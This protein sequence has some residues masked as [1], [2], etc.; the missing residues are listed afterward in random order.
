[1]GIHENYEYKYEYGD[2]ESYKNAKEYVN[3]QVDDINN[4]LNRLGYLMK[5]F[6]KDEPDFFIPDFYIRNKGIRGLLET[7]NVRNCPAR[8]Y[9]HFY[10]HPVIYVKKQDLMPEMTMLVYGLEK[11]LKNDVEIVKE[12]ETR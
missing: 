10:R 11:V 9:L 8:I 3:S 1:M 5:I 6:N 4:R 12:F 7:F 2:N